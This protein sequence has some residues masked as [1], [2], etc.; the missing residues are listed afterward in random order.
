MELH[1]LHSAYRSR[2]GFMWGNL[3]PL[4]TQVTKT[5]FELYK[6][7]KKYGELGSLEGCNW[8]SSPLDW[9]GVV[10]VLVALLLWRD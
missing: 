10:F 6:W 5:I 7:C 1:L 4:R 2:I 3:S 9:L 8:L